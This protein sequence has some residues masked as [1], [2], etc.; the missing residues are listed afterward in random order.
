MIRLGTRGSK[1][2]LYQAEKVKKELEKLGYEV[3]I[4]IIKT[5]GDKILDK[6]I[7]DIGI[8]AFTKELDISLEN[9]EIDIAV[10]SLKDIPTI[11]NPNFDYFVLERDGYKDILLYKNELK[12]DITIGTSSIRRRAFLKNLFPNAKFKLLR[13]NIDTRVRKLKNGEYDA[14]VLSES[15][16]KRLNIDLGDLK[17]FYP[18]ILPA[19]AQGVIAIA[20]KKDDNDIKEILKR[21]NH[22]KTF[23]EVKTERA[24]LNEFGSGCSVPFGALAVF[25]N[26]ILTLKVGVSTQEKYFELS[27]KIKCSINDL[28]RAIK[29]GKELGKELKDA[30]G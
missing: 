16:I 28:D 10:H 25:E 14:I 30:I 5:R 12:E 13:G 15:S 8:G 21:I 4:K 19:P 2:A 20:Y 29:F 18:D 27:K 23:L 6:K 24:A 3:E 11:W 22:K 26:N 17:I 1:L 9:G 7:S